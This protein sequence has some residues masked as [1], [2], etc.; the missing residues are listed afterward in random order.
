MVGDDLQETFLGIKLGNTSIGAYFVG[1]DGRTLPLTDRYL[2]LKWP[3]FPCRFARTEKGVIVGAEALYLLH[4]SPELEIPFSLNEQTADALN[5]LKRILAQVW[6][7]AT[8]EIGRVKHT[9]ITVP[10]NL[11]KEKHQSIISLAGELGFEANVVTH[12]TTLLRAYDLPRGGDQ[13]VMTIRIGGTNSH[14][15]IVRCELKEAHKLGESFLTGFGLRRFVNLIIES[16]ESGPWAGKLDDLRIRFHVTQVVVG[17]LRNLGRGR[18]L[19]LRAEIRGEMARQTLTE[20]EC[21][22]L[23]DSEF[24]TFGEALA[25]LFKKAGISKK[26]VE[27]VLFA[28][29]GLAIPMIEDAL[30]QRIG[31]VSSS[32]TFPAEANQMGA[33]LLA[34]DKPIRNENH[35][36]ELTA[37]SAGDFL[38]ETIWGEGS[39]LMKPRSHKLIVSFRERPNKEITFENR[40]DVTVGRDPKSDIPFNFKLVSRDHARIELHDDAY[41]IIDR[42]INGTLVN[43]KRLVK[44]QRRKLHSGDLVTLVSPYGPGFKVRVVS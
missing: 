28:G 37:H 9:V 40:G 7:R 23:F 19:D 42:S 21:T 36:P 22:A 34:A 3:I 32:Q 33:V 43:G 30:C 38:E 5:M 24:E 4:R 35:K 18:G 8:L 11:T 26:S 6:M 41:F 31:L 20:K 16:L 44:W 27:Q 13:I 14:I 15:S 2:N 1:S 10:D 12:V 39:D 25:E 17:A 29:G